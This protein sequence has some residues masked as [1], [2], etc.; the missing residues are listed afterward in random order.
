MH[1]HMNT[2]QRIVIGIIVCIVVVAGMHLV[3]SPQVTPARQLAASVQANP[4]VPAVVIVM[5][6]TGFTPDT[7]TIN[8]GESVEW[9]NKSTKDFWPAS[10]MHPTHSIYPDSSIFKC[11]TPEEPN[12]FDACSPLS[13]GKSYSFT[14]MY[15]GEWR[16]HDHL[17]PNKTGIIRVE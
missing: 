3:Q 5:D 12:I 14:F 7:V 4:K 17:R 2:T 16:Y 15:K 9:V 8:A 10:N 11:L 6:E 1:N 13:P